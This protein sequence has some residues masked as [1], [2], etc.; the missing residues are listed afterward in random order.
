M[1][2]GDNLSAHSCLKVFWIR[3]LSH[4]AAAAAGAVPSSAVAATVPIANIRHGALIDILL[5]PA[6]SPGQVLSWEPC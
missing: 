1:S 4:G 2:S 3:N 5:A 6:F